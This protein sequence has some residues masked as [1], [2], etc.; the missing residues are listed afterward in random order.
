MPEVRNGK[1]GCVC[2]LS[3]FYHN[4]LCA[5][6][7][8]PTGKSPVSVWHSHNL[9]GLLIPHCHTS[10]CL[11]SPAPSSLTKFWFTHSPSPHGTLLTSP[12]SYECVILSLDPSSAFL[13]HISQIRTG[14]SGKALVDYFSSSSPSPCPPA[15]YR[16]IIFC[17]WTYLA[18]KIMFPSLILS[19]ASY[20]CSDSCSTVQNNLAPTLFQQL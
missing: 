9:S 2:N 3:L 13:C 16:Y 5:S 19:S 4:S 17:F 15:P 8:F 11:C 10:A 12:Y 18:T 20:S 14:F 6:G 7:C 1:C